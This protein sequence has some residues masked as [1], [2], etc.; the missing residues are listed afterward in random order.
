MIKKLT[1]VK[2]PRLTIQQR[3]WICIKYIEFNRNAAAVRRQWIITWP[4][5]VPPREGTI[6]DTFRKFE[7]EGTCHNLHKGRSGRPRTARTE[8]NIDRV[9]E[10]LE[11]NGLRSS[12]RNGMGLSQSSFVRIMRDIKFHPYILIKRQK[13]RPGDPAQRMAF[14]GWFLRSIRTENNFLQNLIVSD[15]AIFSLNSEV[16]THN[17]IQYK[18]HG[19]GH[20]EDH[21]IGHEQGAD[22]VMVWM[23]LTGEGLILG[24]YFIEGGTDTREYIRIVR[25]NVVQRDFRRLNINRRE[26]WWQ[27]DG[28]PSHTSNQAIR[29]LQGQFPGKLISKRGDH[30][31]PARSPDLAIC[32]FFLWGFLK[33]YI[34]EKP[35]AEQPHHL[36]A[37][38]NAIQDASNH[39]NQN[40][41]RRAFQGMVH[42]VRKCMNENGNEFPNE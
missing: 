18:K 27:Q 17:V 34:W 32:D 37:L 7:N 16:N 13:L 38:K 8:A 15:E 9:R 6:S 29:Y 11:N 39:L 12:R 30:N 26:V 4:N 25:Y 41:I 2:M 28:A 5:I 31:W 1:V 40:T 35:V 42:R 24:P 21:Y 3:V 23:G 20:P 22:K 14:G 33:Q 19:E 36:R 10:S